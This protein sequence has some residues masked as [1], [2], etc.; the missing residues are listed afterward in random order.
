MCRSKARSFQ[1]ILDSI[2]RMSFGFGHIAASQLTNPSGSN[3]PEAADDLCTKTAR[4]LR[5]LTAHGV[6]R[7]RVTVGSGWG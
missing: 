4:A 5:R 2:Y 1:V 3:Q 6:R 7:F